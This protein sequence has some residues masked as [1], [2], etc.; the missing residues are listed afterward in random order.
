MCLC[1]HLFVIG[2]DSENDIFGTA[3]YG[4]DEKGY[5]GAI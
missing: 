5:G 3:L 1:V 4:G 2:G